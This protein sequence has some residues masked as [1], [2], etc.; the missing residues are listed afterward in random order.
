MN[1][2]HPL[3]ESPT[4]IPHLQGRGWFTPVDTRPLAIVLFRLEGMSVEGLPP[5]VVRQHIMSYFNSD[6]QSDRLTGIHFFDFPFSFRTRRDVQPF[7][8]SVAELVDKFQE[9]VYFALL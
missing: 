3:T 5:E 6:S 2:D 8:R 9:F 7:E 4:I 1:D